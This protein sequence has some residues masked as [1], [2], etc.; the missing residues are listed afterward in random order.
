MTEGRGTGIPIIRKEMAK[1][2]SPEPRF[3]T[4]ENY[5]YF[6]TT[7][8]VHPAFLENE[9]ED[10]GINEGVND[11]VKQSDNQSDKIYRLI[12]GGVNEIVNVLLNV[13]GL[14]ASEIATRISR[15]PRTTER[16]FQIYYEKK[17]L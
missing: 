10:G 9:S 4:D 5:S 12:Y 1:N 2:G 6:I 16:Y 13:Y 17:K 3:E 11:G 8:P 7:L 15:S 14:N